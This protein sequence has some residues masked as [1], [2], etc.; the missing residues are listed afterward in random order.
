MADLDVQ[1]TYNMLG[2]ELGSVT[3][4]EG[5]TL[6]LTGSFPG[7]VCTTLAPRCR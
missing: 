6:E 3:S 4:R 7:K 1:I 5:G 2:A